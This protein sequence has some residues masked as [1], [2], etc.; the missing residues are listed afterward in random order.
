MQ[1]SILEVVFS[2]GSPTWSHDIHTK[3]HD[4]QLSFEFKSRKPGWL[5]RISC[6]SHVIRS[7]DGMTYPF[8]IHKAITCGAM[9]LVSS[10]Q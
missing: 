5:I 10:L 8:S 3:S 1:R 9:V 4:M 7:H 6:E 2:S